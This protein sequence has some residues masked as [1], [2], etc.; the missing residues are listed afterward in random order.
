MLDEFRRIMADTNIVESAKRAW[1]TFYPK[2]IRQAKIEKGARVSSMVDTLFDN[3]DGKWT[4]K[5]N[6]LAINVYR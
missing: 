5:I 2:I 6:F 4:L 3:E 1:I